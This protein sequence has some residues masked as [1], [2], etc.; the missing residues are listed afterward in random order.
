VNHGLLAKYAAGP[1]L[2]PREGNVAAF[3]RPPSRYMIVVDA[4][5]TYRDAEARSAEQAKWVRF[6]YNGLPR[7][8]QTDAS[9]QQLQE[10]VIVDTWA[11][12]LDFERAHFSDAELAAGLMATG[13]VPTTL[14][15]GELEAR[16]AVLR[17]QSRSLDEVWANWVQHPEKPELALLMWPMLRAKLEAALVDEE[18]LRSIPIARVLLRAYE[19]AT[20]TPRRHVIFKVASDQEAAPGSDDEPVADAAEEPSDSESML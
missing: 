9:L 5:R 7:P 19:L 10:M 8:Y 1:Q 2:G 13:Y 3:L 6:L 16:L 17:S 14:T 12:G 18:Q 4:D 15:R 20:Q 11:E